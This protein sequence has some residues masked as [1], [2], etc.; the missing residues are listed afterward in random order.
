M[1]GYY[2]PAGTMVVT[3]PSM[4]HRLP[5]LWTDPDKF[6]PDRFAEP[7]NEHKKHRYAFAPFGGGAH[8]CI[9]MVFGQLEVK[10]VMHRLLRRTDSSCPA[11]DTG[12]TTTT[13]GCR[14]RWTACRSCCARCANALAPKEFPVVDRSYDRNSFRAASVSSRFAQAMTARSADCVGSSDQPI[15]H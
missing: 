5:E 10:T 6:D 13:A 8:K 12:R 14:S 4:N 11:P 3:W 9:G 7:R 15:A 2:L 1:L